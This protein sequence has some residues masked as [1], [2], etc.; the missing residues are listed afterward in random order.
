[1]PATVTQTISARSHGRYVVRRPEGAFRVAVV[2]FHGYAQR[3]EHLLAEL[4]ALPGAGGWLLAS[5]EGLNRFYD[6]ETG[7]VVAHW[8][9]HEDGEPVIADTVAYVDAVVAAI[10]R[11]HP[12]E[13]LVFAGFSQGAAMASRAA[14]HAGDRCHGLVLLGGELA[15]EVRR[16]DA[17]LPRTVI[18]RG[19]RDAWY[20][21]DAFAADCEA[22]ED[23]G[24][25]AAAVEFNGGHEFSPTFRSTAAAFIATLL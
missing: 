10:A 21:A 23:R 18:G 4:E 13:R 16:S 12:F 15:P 20:A 19:T 1:M 6:R 8:L 17:R 5:V 2:G 14:A 7:T 11:A 25:L 24:V 22:L 3:A 9:T